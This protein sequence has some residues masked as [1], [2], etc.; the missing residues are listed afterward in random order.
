M[1]PSRRRGLESIQLTVQVAVCVTVAADRGRLGEAPCDGIRIEV[2]NRG[3]H[4]VL[5]QS[6]GFLLGISDSFSQIVVV[7]RN[8]CRQ[9]R[10]QLRD[11]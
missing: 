8:L 7:R 11:L 1:F 4:A 10:L 5:E 3:S 2:R 9:N 6:S